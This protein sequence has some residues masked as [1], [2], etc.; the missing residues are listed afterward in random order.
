MKYSLLF[1]LICFNMWAEE[2]KE[3]PKTEDLTTLVDEYIKKHSSDSKEEKW[4]KDMTQKF[5]QKMKDNQSI[6]S[7][8][9]CADLSIFDWLADRS[10]IFKKIAKWDKETKKK[11]EEYQKTPNGEKYKPKDKPE[12]LNNEDKLELC[13]WYKLYINK[14]WQFADNVRKYITVENY[15]LWIEDEQ[16]S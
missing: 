11:Q 5:A 2:S 14:K 6:S 4:V 15:R 3:P 16:R 10:E 8:S 12:G 13:R 9:Q 1:T 7:E